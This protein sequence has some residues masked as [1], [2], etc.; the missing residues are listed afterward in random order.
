MN[1]LKQLIFIIFGI[2]FFLIG[3]APKESES[4]VA[5]IGSHKVNMGEYENF[6]AKNSGGW[7]A[8][9]D[10]TMESREHF[11]DLLVNYRLKLQDA[12]DRNLQNDP[13]LVSEITE[14][15]S[16]L[17]SSFIIDKEITTPGVQHLYDLKKEEIR[18]QYILI[19]LKQDATPEDT[20]KAWSKAMEVVKLAQAGGNFDSLVAKYSEDE[21]SKDVRGDIY[22]FTG[23]MLMFPL[24]T[25]AYSM[26]KGEISA[27]PVRTPL[28]YDILKITDRQPARGSMKARHLMIRFP[29]E[30]DSAKDTLVPLSKIKE[31][32]DSLKKGWDFAKLAM[33]FSDDGGSASNGGDLGWFERRRWIQAFDEAAFKLSPGETSPIV[34]TQ[35]GYHLIH[36]D[37]VK[38]MPSYEGMQEDLKKLYQQYRF[39]D[40]YNA[41]VQKMK[42]DYKYTFNDQLFESMAKGLDSTRTIEDSAWIPNLPPDLRKQILYTVSGKNFTLDTAL[43]ILTRRPDYK[44]TSLRKSELRS[45]FDHIGETLL[46]DEKAVGL[47]SRYSDFDALMKDYEDGIV[48]F[49]AEQMQ[50]WNKIT[51]GDSL[52]KAYFNANRTKFLAPAKVNIAEIHLSTDTLAM[53]AYDTLTKGADFGKLADIYNDDNELKSKQG[54]RGLEPVNTDE[55]T[56]YADSLNVG[57]LSD[58]IP[59]ETGGYSIIKVISKEP[60]RQKTFEEAGAEVSNTLQES[61]SKRI[62]G[63]WLDQL[64]QKYP[65][66]KHKEQLVKAFISTPPMK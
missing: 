10:S 54:V 53:M 64:M 57:E 11:L 6:F 5:E 21:A 50:V 63:A 49:K 22:Y 61:E 46:F 34:K 30:V 66:V 58:P 9:K 48:L 3:C 15:R 2:T 37:S 8:A 35:Y 28:G 25:A 60:G 39:N 18:A 23:G 33:K 51:I 56:K 65:V 4:V 13:E 16:S 20:A 29:A 43:S 19:A 45:K 32:Q 36:C 41:Y 27:M 14:Y 42:T 24:E 44:N 38:S 7:E 1:S 17:A 26:K 40:D 52:L 47:E 62:E 31:M 55:L 12:Y 59:L